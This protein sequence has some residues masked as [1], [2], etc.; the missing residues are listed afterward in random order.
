MTQRRE[1]PKSNNAETQAVR[2]S[3]PRES[4]P[5]PMRFDDRKAEAPFTD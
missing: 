4:L 1:L 5:S 3:A 2:K